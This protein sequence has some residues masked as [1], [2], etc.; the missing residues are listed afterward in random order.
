MSSFEVRFWD[1][2]KLE[3]K[4]RP[5]Q[6]RW[7]VA[8]REKSRTFATRALADSFRS[9]LVTKARKG[10]AFDEETGL[11]V[12][13]ARGRSGRTW[14]E[15][16]CAY[17][18]MKWPH[19][20]ATSRRSI[21]EALVTV[22]PVLTRDMRG[23]PDDETLRRALFGWAFTPT[24]RDRVAPA[25]IRA[26][27]DWAERASLPVASLAEP[28]TVRLVLGAISTTTGGRPAAATTARRKRAVFSNALR[29]AVECGELDENPLPKVQ[30]SAPKV[31]E[32]IDRRVVANP[33]QV[34]SLLTAV[35]EQGGARAKLAVFFACIYFAGMRPSEVVALRVSD[36]YL[37]AGGWGRLDLIASEPRAGRRWTDDGTV[38]DVRQLKH[39][40]VAAVRPVPIPPELV[41]LL[42]AYLAEHGAA[43]DGRL[44]RTGS[45]SALQNSMIA[46]TWRR[47]RE[48]ALTPEQYASPLARRPYDLR[49][50][51]ATLWLN[52]GVPATEVAR[53]LGHSVVVLLKIY[54][55]CLD[56]QEIIA[57]V[58]IEQALGTA[59]GDAGLE[60]GD[61][62]HGDGA[63]GDAE[64]AR[65]GQIDNHSDAA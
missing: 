63:H 28:D 25:E 48:M 35:A 23:R 40:A 58:S 64:Q 45:G 22:T 26:A 65:N 41:Q 62:R 43:P 29:Y 46:W 10:E 56:G 53:R 37:P 27:L 19:A 9:N 17:V 47:A 32:V 44:F 34:R 7:V 39:R 5:Y 18:D 59:A 61:R 38:R 52:S 51:A 2:R 1:V 12:D 16:A 11:P 30:W 15:H 13:E 6:V 33:V 8:G 31:A 4:R 55:N 36:C 3:G 60:G 21:A 20:A 50:A 49:H 57:N 42:R 14:Y 24:G 54:A